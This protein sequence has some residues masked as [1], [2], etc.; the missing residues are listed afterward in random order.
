VSRRPIT[1]KERLRRLAVR[2]PICCALYL[3]PT[4]IMM[5]APMTERLAAGIR[6]AAVVALIWTILDWASTQGRRRPGEGGN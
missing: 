4:W 6:E 3:L 5:I 1:W 2:V